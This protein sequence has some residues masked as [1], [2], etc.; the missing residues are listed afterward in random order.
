MQHIE[1]NFI[2]ME[3]VFEVNLGKG[4]VILCIYQG[5]LVRLIVCTTMD[6]RNCI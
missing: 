1:D 4:Q 2:K 3:I 5:L 6:L